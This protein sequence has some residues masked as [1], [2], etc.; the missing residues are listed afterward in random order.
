MTIKPK[1]KIAK[2]SIT[3]KIK[4]RRSNPNPVRLRLGSLLKATAL[5]VR[6]NYDDFRHDDSLNVEEDKKIKTIIKDLQSLAE[7][8]GIRDIEADDD[9]EEYWRR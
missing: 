5:S 8:L 4:S 2:K 3:S 1:K 6:R 9:S 7:K